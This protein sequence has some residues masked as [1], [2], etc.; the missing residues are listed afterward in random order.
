[1]DR[2][3]SAISPVLDTRILGFNFAVAALAALLFGLLPALRLSRTDIASSLK[4]QAGSH[5]GGHEGRLRKT[6][7]IVQVTI[8]FLLLIGAGLFIQSLR[9]LRKVDPGFRPANLIR[10][11][12]DPMLSGYDVE[13]TKEFYRRLQERLESSPGV[14]SSALSVVPIMEGDE[15]DSTI[16]VAGYQ[17]KDGEDMN[18]HFNSIS[19]GYFAT[20]GIPFLLGRDFDEQLGSPTRKA[21]IV[22]QTFARR[23]F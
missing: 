16:T 10:F 8:C 14:E 9:N 1:M 22:N 13:R 7:V 5:S 18:S 20:L 3:R 17:A 21:A 15:W 11:K 12:L 2:P 23:Y 6:L 19:R 4:E